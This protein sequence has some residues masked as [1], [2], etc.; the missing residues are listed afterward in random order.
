MYSFND[1]RNAFTASSSRAVPL[2]RHEGRA[3]HCRQEA[4]LLK[5][6]LPQ[7]QSD[8]T[9]TLEEFRELA[10]TILTL[11]GLTGAEI[12]AAEKIF[13]SW[14]CSTALNQS[15]DI[16]CLVS[17]PFFW[18]RS[19]FKAPRRESALS[20]AAPGEFRAPYP[21]SFSRFLPPVD[22]LF[23]TFALTSPLPSLERHQRPSRGDSLQWSE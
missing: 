6:E 17:A 22:L 16:D 19:G 1:S 18:S 12:E 5:S 8:T 9:P 4:A 20:I 11:S 13:T 14:T 7:E 23:P 10:Q 15:L 21:C 3:V 2:S